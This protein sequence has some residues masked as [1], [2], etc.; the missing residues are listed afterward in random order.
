[1]RRCTCC[2]WCVRT[3]SRRSGHLSTTTAP[4]QH[5][6]RLLCWCSGCRARLGGEGTHQQRDG[7]PWRAPFCQ[8]GQRLRGRC[9]RAVRGRRGRS[10]S[11]WRWCL[12]GLGGG[13][14]VVPVQGRCVRLTTPRR[15]SVRRRPDAWSVLRSEQLVRGR[16]VDEPTRG[17]EPWPGGVVPRGLVEVAEVRAGSGATEPR[18]EDVEDLV[19]AERHAGCFGDRPGEE[20][21]RGP[22]VPGEAHG[23]DLSGQLVDTEGRH[24]V[25]VVA[26]AVRDEANDVVAGLVGRALEELDLRRRACKQDQRLDHELVRVNEGARDWVDG[27]RPACNVPADADLV[28]LPAGDDARDGVAGFV[29]GGGDRELDAVSYTHL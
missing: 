13:R 7:S 14:A 23:V 28:E 17:C 12:P 27:S 5:L 24:L 26:G 18:P 3:S 6:R 19:V 9:L 22:K 11:S 10:G 29:D 16:L 25:E 4:A 15:S 20:D 1:M 21:D 2:R 8:R